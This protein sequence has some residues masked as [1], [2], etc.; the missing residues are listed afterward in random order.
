DSLQD[1]RLDFFE[2]RPVDDYLFSQD[3]RNRF[4]KVIEDSEDGSWNP[5]AYKSFLKMLA[6][7][8][9]TPS[10][11]LLNIAELLYG[12]YHPGVAMVLIK[13]PV[14]KTDRTI[15]ETLA[16]LPSFNNSEFYKQVRNQARE[17]LSQLDEQRN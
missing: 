9:E 8:T 3:V 17:F 2:I 11:A 16:E 4:R 6:R 7:N 14:I 13:N 1:R 15:L 10:D 12:E 5:Q